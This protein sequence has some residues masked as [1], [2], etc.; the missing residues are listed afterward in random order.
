MILRIFFFTDFADAVIGNTPIFPDFVM[1]SFFRQGMNLIPMKPIG[2]QII[3][4]MKNVY[5]YSE[6]ERNKDSNLSN[7]SGKT[8]EIT[9]IV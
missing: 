4:I 7:K 8:H 9:R 1:N 2:S 3:A 6:F 5:K